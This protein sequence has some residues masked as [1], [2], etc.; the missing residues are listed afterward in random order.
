MACSPFGWMPSRPATTRFARR[1]RSSRCSPGSARSRRSRGHLLEQRALRRIGQRRS[2]HRRRLHAE[3]QWRRRIAL[4]RGRPAIS[5]RSACRSCW[6]ARSR[7]QDRPDGRPVCVIN[8]TFAKRF[9]AGRHPIGLHVTQEYAE[10]RH[11]YEVVG[12]V[13]DS[14]QNRLRGE[15]EHRFYTPATQPAAS[16]ERGDVH[17]PA[18]RRRLRRPRRR[19]AHH[20]SRPSRRCRSARG[21]PSTE[22]IDTADRPG[23]AAGP[24]LD[25]IR[26]RRRAAGRDRVSTACCPTASRAAPTRSASARRSARSPH[27]DRHDPARD[28]WLLVVGLSPESVCPSR[29]FG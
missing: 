20:P 3:G 13:R 26:R 23:S 21:G 19:P 9:F 17:H 29:R 22:A 18:A 7:E 5:R 25:R 10:Q 14:R 28:G 12:V 11:T 2:D 27:A 15:I 24:A 16:I 4:R 6:V 8:E 1:P